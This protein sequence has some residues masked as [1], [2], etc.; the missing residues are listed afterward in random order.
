M[1]PLW[2]VMS[3][4][5][6]LLLALALAADAFSVGAALALRYQTARQ[7]FR[8][9]FHFGLFQALLPLLGALI[10]GALVERVDHWVAFGLLALVGGRMIWSGLH[11]DSRRAGS[12]DLTRG[13]SLVGL[14]V[15]VSIDALAVGITLPATGAPVGV[16]VTTFGVVAGLATLVAMRL[17]APF[18]RR[19]GGRVE[20]VAGLVLIALGVKT[21]QDHIGFLG[22]G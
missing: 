19:L 21:L 3:F 11:E 13:W 7:V 14:S 6:I 5:Q 15:A 10:G 16:A 22:L 9:A 17:V 4:L 1:R 18:A 12:T 20:V 2:P 8:V